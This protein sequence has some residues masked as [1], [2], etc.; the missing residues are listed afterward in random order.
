MGLGNLILITLLVLIAPLLGLASEVQFCAQHKALMQT[1]FSSA[2]PIPDHL[3]RTLSENDLLLI[4]ETHHEKNLGVLSAAAIS[5]LKK[6]EKPCVFLEFEYNDHVNSPVCLGYCDAA[7]D[8]EVCRGRY[9][10]KDDVPTCN[11]GQYLVAKQAFVNEIPIHVVD[12]NKRNCGFGLSPEETIATTTCRDQKIVEEIERL[13]GPGKE[14][15][16]AFFVVGSSHLVE[17]GPGRR[18]I[19]E[20]LETSSLKTKSCLIVDAEDK[21]G[22]DF[23]YPRDSSALRCPEAV[24]PFGSNFVSDIQTLDFNFEVA[25]TKNLGGTYDRYNQIDC[26]YHMAC[27]DLNH[28][29]CA[30]PPAPDFLK[31]TQLYDV[32][33]S[34]S[35]EL[36]APLSLPTRPYDQ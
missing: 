7:V 9:K 18:N 15:R 13:L 1:L 3:T 33:F 25:M 21:T 29:S 19:L 30:S 11:E 5:E 35:S 10:W 14:C 23:L 31:D 28:T 16:K 24:R 20:R 34:E 8:G 2:S 12:V 36:G 26:V 4:G 32:G 6:Y 22:N 17:Q 27:S